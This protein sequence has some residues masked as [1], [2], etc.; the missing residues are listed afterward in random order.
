MLHRLLT[1]PSQLLEEDEDAAANETL[2]ALATEG[3]SDLQD[4]VQPPGPIC[5]S[6]LTTREE[7]EEE[8]EEEGEEE[9][10]G[11]KVRRSNMLD[12]YVSADLSTFITKQ[13]EMIKHLQ[14]VMMMMMMMMMMAV[15]SLICFLC[16]C[17]E[18]EAE[19][20]VRVR[21]VRPQVQSDVSPEGSPSDSH[22]R[23]RW[24]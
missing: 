2:A 17:A 11:R 16:V 12:V 5:P 9:D 3:G 8:E 1:L 21:G 24:R 22:C 4:S 23:K 6:P 10:K 20:V 7:E 18:E 19:G 15:C 14:S 13:N